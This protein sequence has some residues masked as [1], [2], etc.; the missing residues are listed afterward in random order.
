MSNLMLEVGSP[1]TTLIRERKGIITSIARR[2]VCDFAGYWGST[3]HAYL[4]EFAPLNEDSVPDFDFVGYTT[5]WV[6]V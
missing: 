3:Y 5:T 4:V 6:E 1:I 2:P